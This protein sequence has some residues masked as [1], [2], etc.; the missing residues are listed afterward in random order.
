ML[1][2]ALQLIKEAQETP[3]TQGLNQQDQYQDNQNNY[4]NSGPPGNQEIHMILKLVHLIR[5][6]EIRITMLILALQLI[7]EA[8]EIDNGGS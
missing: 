2:L 8:Q 5:T 1:I 6:K 3:I 4:A 7:K